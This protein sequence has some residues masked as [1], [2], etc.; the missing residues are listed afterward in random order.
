MGGTGGDRTG[1]ATLFGGDG[2]DT[3]T[4]VDANPSGLAS[5]ELHGGDGDDLVQVWTE[6]SQGYGGEGDDD[7][8]AGAFGVLLSGG[9]GNDT[10]R[11]IE[12]GRGTLEGG[13]GADVF[14][15]GRNEFVADLTID[16]VLVHETMDAQALSSE[17][18]VIDGDDAAGSA[19]VSL[20]RSGPP[21][22]AGSSAPVIIS[23][24]LSDL[25]DRL[26]IVTVRAGTREVAEDRFA[27]DFAH[28]LHLVGEAARIVQKAEGLLL[29][30]AETA[31]DFEG[32][33]GSDTLVGS[34]LDDVL[35][36]LD[37]DDAITGDAGHDTL[38]GGEGADLLTGG[39]GDDELH[40]GAGDDTLFGGE[41]DDLLLGGA[42]DDLIVLGDS[43]F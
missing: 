14:L 2:D 12:D 4:S 29:V 28:E 36:G 10:L 24:E 5:A 35:Y 31:L 1:I 13:E 34:L 23:F 21:N 20:L 38:F 41:G 8:W 11:F 17:A 37:G 15:V 27:P 7:L 40:G 32:S 43:L 30:A 18:I 3:L 33:S 39:S 16:D 19:T 22:D 42:G 9:S 26:T 6:R 25:P